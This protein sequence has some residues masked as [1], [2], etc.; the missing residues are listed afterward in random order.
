MSPVVTSPQVQGIEKVI[1]GETWSTFPYNY[2]HANFQHR[3][4]Q[5]AKPM[6]TRPADEMDWNGSKLLGCI[7]FHV[8]VV[9][10]F[11]CMC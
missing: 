4:G 9:L 3:R 7:Y 6:L 11:G 5:Q 2:E 8:D 10:A 1:V